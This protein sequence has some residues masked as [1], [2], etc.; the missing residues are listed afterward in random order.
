MV[1]QDYIDTDICNTGKQSREK[2]VLHL[3]VIF[4]QRKKKEP[5]LKFEKFIKHTH[6]NMAIIILSSPAV[7]L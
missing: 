7:E 4:S 1:V 3:L 5:K 6:P 2:E